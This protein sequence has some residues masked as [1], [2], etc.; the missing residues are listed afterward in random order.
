MVDTYR[1]IV[2]L[3]SG[4]SGRRIPFSV[5]KTRA[6]G[7]YNQMEVRSLEKWV[8]SWQQ[9]PARDGSR[10]QLE[11]GDFDDLIEE[12][13]ADHADVVMQRMREGNR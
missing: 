8:N 4:L 1:D 10:C 5:R 7:S 12:A 13:V 11:R 3:G 9:S 2:N 6:A